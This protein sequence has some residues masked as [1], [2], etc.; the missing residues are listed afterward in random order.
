M[1][2][3]LAVIAVLT[4]L[5]ACDQSPTRITGEDVLSSPSAE[6]SSS[7]VR[8]TSSVRWNRMAMSL[9]RARGG[10]AGRVNAYFSLAQYQAALAASGAKHGS[11]QPSLAGAVAAASDRKSVV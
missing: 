5:S 6:R 1:K 3:R 10:N 11:S 2:F 9:F 4:L 8:A 7:E